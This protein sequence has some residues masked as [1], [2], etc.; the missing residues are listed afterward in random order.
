MK[1]KFGNFKRNGTQK[2]LVEILSDPSASE[3]GSC[4]E[5]M[6]KQHPFDMKK[7]TSEGHF[8]TMG[9]VGN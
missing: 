2:K 3:Q 9:G 4:S 8:K 1:L 5:Q 7:L 6:L